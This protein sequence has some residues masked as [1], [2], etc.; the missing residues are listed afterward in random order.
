MM[1]GADTARELSLTLRPGVYSVGATQ[2]Q[3]TGGKHGV[4]KAAI[5]G[6]TV[7]RMARF[8]FLFP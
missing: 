6:T 5:T 7:S 2:A 1:T 4:I 8:I 3:F